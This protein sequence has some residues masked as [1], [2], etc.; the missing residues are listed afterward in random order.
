MEQ[1]ARS[2]PEAIFSLIDYLQDII[3]ELE[4]RISEVERQQKTDSSNSRLAALERRDREA[5][6]SP[7]A[8]VLA[9]AWWSGRP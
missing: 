8:E 5:N 4:R 2:E 3:E 9:K 7:A 1:L 6:V